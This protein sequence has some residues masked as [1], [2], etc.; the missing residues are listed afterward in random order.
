MVLDWKLQSSKRRGKRGNKFLF[1]FLHFAFF[2]FFLK[3]LCLEMQYINLT[4]LNSNTPT[5]LALSVWLSVQLPI[6]PH[7]NL[8]ANL[9]QK[10]YVATAY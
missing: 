9:P 10:C 3:L 4:I 6:P 2:L 1:F 8:P 7:L 5:Y